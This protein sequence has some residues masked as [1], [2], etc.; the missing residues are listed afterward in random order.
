MEELVVNTLSVGDK[1]NLKSVEVISAL[2]HHL[3][4][5]ES[6]VVYAS[7]LG[8]NREAFTFFF[9]LL[10][11]LANELGARALWASI[12]VEWSNLLLKWMIKGDRPYWWVGETDLYSNETRPELRQFANTCES[13]PGTPS[14]H[15]M[16]NVALFYVATKGISK[17]FIWNTKAFSTCQKSILS[18]VL[19]TAYLL[20]IGLIFVSRLYIQAHFIH[21]NILGIIVGLMVG[22]VAW[23]SK[24]LVKLSK[25]WA[26]VVACSLIGTTVSTYSLLL[27]QGMNPLWSVPLALKHCARAEYVKIDTQPF[28]LAM[29]F[30]GAALGLGLGLSS[31]QRHVVLNAPRN[32]I[33]TILIIK[34]GIVIGRMASMIQGSLPTDDMILFLTLS[35]GLNIAL[36]FIIIA[37]LPHFL[38]TVYYGN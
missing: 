27:S 22:H 34:G 17:H 7:V 19:Y 29:R 15:I 33:R 36:P 20:W 23:S 4:P 25:V 38:L 11:G 14:G 16:M 24:W 8:D 5:Y 37:L 31:D 10:A 12:L 30:T 2:Q 6:W 28:Y 3:E 35:F 18:A 26:V 32:C 9:P 1:W 21:Q 13:G